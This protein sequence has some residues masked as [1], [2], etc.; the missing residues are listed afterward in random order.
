M[1]RANR[2]IG[3]L[4]VV[5]VA[6]I[7]AEVG[8]RV[9]N[10]WID[11]ASY[12]GLWLL[13]AAVMALVGQRFSPLKDVANRWQGEA[14]ASRQMPPF[15]TWRLA[16]LLFLAVTSAVFACRLLDIATLGLVV[17]ASVQGVLGLVSRSTHQ[18]WL[19][20]GLMLIFAGLGYLLAPGMYAPSPLGM[21]L[22]LISGAAWASFWLQVTQGAHQ[23]DVIVATSLRMS[24]LLVLPLIIFTLPNGFLSLRGVGFAVLAGAL[25]VFAAGVFWRMMASTQRLL[26]Q[27][28]IWVAVL[29]A[30]M[31]LVAW[32]QSSMMNMRLTSAAVVVV[33]GVVV[34]GVAG[35]AEDPDQLT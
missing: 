5:V 27:Q 19:W 22:G 25:F 31:G 14:L 16:G 7:N 30:L 35:R 3:A 17:V 28:L 21:V 18:H 11:P 15:T 1:K 23:A 10:Q 13:S 24:L 32:D 8:R 26:A 29:L 20:M 33:V 4:V 6:V 9:I 34:I 12:I 2:V